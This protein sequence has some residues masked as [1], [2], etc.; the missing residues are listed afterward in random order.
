MKIIFAY[1]DFEHNGK[2]PE[3]YHGFR[4]CE[5]NF[6][7]DYTYSL[8]TE[9]N[10]C[11]IN[12]IPLP[13]NQQIEPGFWTDPRIYNATAIVGDNGS[14]KTT[15]LHTLLRACLMNSKVDF[16]FVILFEA[17]NSEENNNLHLYTNMNC[18]FMETNMNMKQMQE[19]PKELMKTKFMLLDNTLS[20]SGIEIANEFEKEYIEYHDTKPNQQ[21]ITMP[22]EKAGKQ[23][24]N[25]SLISSLCYSNYISNYGMPKHMQETTEQIATHLR[26]EI[27][28]E[29]RYVFDKYQR[30]TLLDLKINGFNAPIPQ[31][32]TINIIPPKL[33][34]FDQYSILIKNNNCTVTAGVL[35]R[36]REM[37]SEKYANNFL[38][39]LG[40]NCVANYL[41]QCA[42]FCPSD[43]QMYVYRKFTEN[44]IELFIDYVNQYDQMFLKKLSNEF[45][46]STI[47]FLEFIAQNKDI[48]CT[49]FVNTKEFQYVV[50][51]DDKLNN[52]M[53]EFV[54]KYRAMCGTHYFLT[55]SWGMSSGESNLLR[56]FTK[57]RY[58]LYGP[59]YYDETT[60]IQHNTQNVIVNKFSENNEQICDSLIILIDEADLSYHPEWQRSFIALLTAF[61]PKLYKNPYYEGS[62][63]GCKNIQL[64]LTTHSPLMLGDFPMAS[65]IYLR[66]YNGIVKIEK[67]LSKNPFG[68]NLYT[69]LKDGF[70]MKRTMGELAHLKLNE[71]IKGLNYIRNKIAE[72]KSMT[73]EHISDILEKLEQYQKTIYH[74]PDGII[75][76]KIQRE[77]DDCRKEINYVNLSMLL[78]RKK[79][80][81]NELAEIDNAIKK[82]E[83]RND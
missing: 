18:E 74:L 23:L 25:E 10:I 34:I 81:M 64:I 82:K 33:Y 80:L 70:Y 67:S 47:N 14:G 66:K 75:R 46:T 29:F 38:Y 13:E 2:H 24:F 42:S 52:F 30:D 44:N 40:F 35:D 21:K 20:F 3:G 8:M 73:D 62:E 69:I 76:E 58:L 57:F 4:Q 68:Q 59:T 36:L 65:V 32:L 16:E 49:E 51:I 19:Y 12:R 54:N 45:Y 27:Y 26:Y 78:Q 60:N 56:M 77:I 43:D 11:K 83:G 28:Q 53:I 15:L 37:Y 9:G 63:E 5:L 22:K 72:S 39:N 55:F 50:T 48:I 41:C 6:S 79:A 71:V 7:T 1:F 31:K 61:L 17:D